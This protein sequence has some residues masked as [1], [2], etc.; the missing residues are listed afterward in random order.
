MQ[1]SIHLSTLVD[2]AY[3]VTF[4]TINT[5]AEREREREHIENGNMCLLPV[6]CSALHNASSN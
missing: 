6:T 2:S 1:L 3:H 5:D 4:K